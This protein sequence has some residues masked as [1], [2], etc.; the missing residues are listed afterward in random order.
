MISLY[1]QKIAAIQPSNGTNLY[2]GL[3]NGIRHI[4]ADRT[5][6]IV[7]VTDGVAN[8]GETHQRQFIE[9]I[10][11]KD[12]RLLTMIMGNSSIF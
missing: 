10:K 9:L 5:S 6:A 8:V 3:T 11:K 2:Q 4:D 1:S 7:L 12:I